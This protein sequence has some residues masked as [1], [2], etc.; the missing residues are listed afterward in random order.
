MLP[1]IILGKQVYIPTYNLMFGIGLIL[2]ILVF[3][4]GLKKSGTYPGRI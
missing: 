1:Y 3:E 4:S 2:G